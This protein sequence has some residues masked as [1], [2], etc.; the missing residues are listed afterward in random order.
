MA[1]TEATITNINLAKLQLFI[2]DIAFTPSTTVSSHKLQKALE[3]LL[4]FIPTKLILFP[5]C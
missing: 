4:G 3:T 2:L 1:Y 5:Y